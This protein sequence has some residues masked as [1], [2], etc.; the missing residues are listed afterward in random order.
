MIFTALCLLPFPSA[1][2]WVAGHATKPAVASMSLGVPSGVWSQS[3]ETAVKNLVAK[4]I[5]VV[6]A[7]GNSAQDSCQ[8]APARVP[9]AVTVAAS[10]LPNK[11]QQ[12]SSGTSLR[13]DVYSAI[14]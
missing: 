8:V 1:L 3:L 2:D 9:E 12:T 10:N 14:S 11:F 6:V 4:G 13:K 7:A 5:P